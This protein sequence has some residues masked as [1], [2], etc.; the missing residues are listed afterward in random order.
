MYLRLLS[1]G[2]VGVLSFIGSWSIQAN[3]YERQLSDL[4]AEYAQARDKAIEEAH[5]KTIIL[6]ANKDKA[7][8]EAKKRIQVLN[9]DV[10]STKSALVSLSD[11][12]DTA[13]R[14]ANNSHSACIANANTLTVVFGQCAVRL[15]EVAEDADGLSIDLQTVVEAWPQ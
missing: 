14:T 15:S 5:A 1:Y 8:L 3:R 10:A 13:L 12:T 9:R 7:L 2:L 6:Q 11:A 4:K